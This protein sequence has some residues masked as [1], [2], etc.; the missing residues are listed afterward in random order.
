MMSYLSPHVT[1]S[2]SQR[3]RWWQQW[4]DWP[5][6]RCL[7]TLMAPSEEDQRSF[8]LE[9]LT[10]LDSWSEFLFLA[11]EHGQG[12]K[13]WPDE[14]RK[15][16]LKLAENRKQALPTQIDLLSISP[17]PPTPASLLTSWLELP[18][19]EVLEI[20]AWHNQQ[21]FSPAAVNNYWWRLSNQLR[22]VMKNSVANW[23]KTVMRY[24]FG[25]CC[26]RGLSP[27]KNL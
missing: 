19:E 11:I 17:G 5:E 16:L 7:L 22:N 3:Q 27:G 13:S 10:A 2:Q 14:Q 9:Y 26:W 6:L 12:F 18:S 21:G 4:Q 20:R 8:V 1:I 15:L 24:G 23:R 25:S